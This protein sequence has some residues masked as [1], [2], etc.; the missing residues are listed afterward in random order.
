LLKYKN[1]RYVSSNN[2]PSELL[3][4]FGENSLYKQI[5]DVV[6]V[7]DKYDTFKNPSAKEA[8]IGNSRPEYL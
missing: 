8:I 7:F 4:S 2:S 3:Y 5:K 1:G 6:R